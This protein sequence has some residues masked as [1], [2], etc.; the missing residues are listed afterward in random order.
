MRRDV[1]AGPSA[2]VRADLRLAGARLPRA[3]GDVPAAAR[4]P[5]LLIR[6]LQDTSAAG[7]LAPPPERPLTPLLAEQVT[8]LAGQIAPELPAPVIALAIVAWT[9]LFGMISF[10]LF[11]HLVGS[12]DPGEQFFDHACRTMA[13]LL[14]LPEEG[15]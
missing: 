6:Q 9:Q 12:V 4:V 5:L 7:A 8:A 1:G 11:G 13:D 3:T 14:G 15:A 2:R 10:E